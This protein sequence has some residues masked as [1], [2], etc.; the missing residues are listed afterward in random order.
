MLQKTSA[1]ILFLLAFG[2]SLPEWRLEA[3]EFLSGAEVTIGADE[4][5]N[6]DVYAVAGRVIVDGTVNGDLVAAGDNIVV[7]GSINGDLIVAARAVTVAGKVEDDIRAAAANLRF[8]S[9]VGGD[10]I[11]AGSLIVIEVDSVIGEDLVASAGTL[12]ARGDVEGDLD[13]NV[14]EAVIEGMVQGNV[15]ATVEDSLVLGPE[16]TIGGELTYTGLNEVTILPGAELTGDPT[17]LMPTMSI[18]GDEY[19][20][21]ALVAFLSRIVAQTKWFIGTILVGLLLIWLMP[22]TVRSVVATLSNS[23]WRSFGMGLFMLPVTPVLL[24]LTMII[25]LS[26]VGFSAFPIVAVP[27]ATYAVLLLLAKPVIAVSIG[28]LISKLAMKRKDITLRS[29]LVSGAAVLAGAGLIPYLDSIVGWLTLILGFGMWL[30]YSYRQYRGARA[31]QI[32]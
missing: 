5:L 12:I 31:A 28:K 25:A 20:F 3:A 18:L 32:A 2:L 9:S 8:L 1:T 27:G 14:S 7:N 16:S 30:L 10:L 23:P 22:E 11:A 4:V 21:S 26:M 19:P 17:K 24:L 15:K 29:A 6:E 13:L